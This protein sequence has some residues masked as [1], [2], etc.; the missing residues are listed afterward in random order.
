[1]TKDVVFYQLSSKFVDND[2]EIPDESADVLYYSLQI[3]HHTGII[4]CFSEKFRCPY[5][6]YLS[7]I[8]ALPEESAARYKLE[9]VI[10]HG[11]I[12]IDKSH[13]ATLVPALKELPLL[14]APALLKALLAA[15][16]TIA[17]QPSVYLMI[18]VQ[19]A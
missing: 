11:E 4:D 16:D 2:R 9:G 13:L 1:M 10:R 5:R 17:S 7:L 19:D 6:A 3:G 12:Q 15:L 8:E 18:R 14:E